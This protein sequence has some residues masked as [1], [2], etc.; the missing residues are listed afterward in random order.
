M[1]RRLLAV[2]IITAF[3]VS[4]TSCA[5]WQTPQMRMETI[6][7]SYESVGM[8]AFPAVLAYLKQREIN[9]SLAGDALAKAKESYREAKAIYIR[10]GDLLIVFVGGDGQAPQPLM[11]QVAILL[12]EV[13]K[14]LADLSGGKVDGNKLTVPMAGGV[15]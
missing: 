12:Q 4:F 10:A 5:G 14:I 15:K 1:K 6:T 2:V 13:A 7:I 9:G 8:V 11:A 3:V